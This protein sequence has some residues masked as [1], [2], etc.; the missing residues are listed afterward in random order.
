MISFSEISALG[1]LL[2]PEAG[3][4][5]LIS[6]VCSLQSKTFTVFWNGSHVDGSRS[7]ILL[8]AA[9]VLS[10]DGVLR[11]LSLLCSFDRCLILLKKQKSKVAVE[12]QF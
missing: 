4:F 12:N 7:V 1:I 2:E 6:S 9:G 10:L 3:H 11:M 5:S 8:C